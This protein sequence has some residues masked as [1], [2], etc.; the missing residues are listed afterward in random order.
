MAHIRFATESDIP[1]IYGFIL[2]MAR[3]EKLENEVDTTKGTANAIIFFHGNLLISGTVSIDSVS[4]NHT[5]VAPENGE[6]FFTGATIVIEGTGKMTVADADETFLDSANVLGAAY[7]TD[8]A[9]V[10]TSLN[11][12]IASTVSDNGRDVYVYGYVQTG[13]WT[14]TENPDGVTVWWEHP[15]VVSADIE[16]PANITLNIKGTLEIAE[17][18]VSRDCEPAHSVGALPPVR[19]GRWR[20]PRPRGFELRVGVDLAVDVITSIGK[21]ITSI[22]GG[23]AQHCIYVGCEPYRR[24]YY[25]VVVCHVTRILQLYFRTHP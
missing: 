23:E 8:D 9:Y 16:I 15:Y 5:T 1:L 14:D 11:D 10:L 18:V 20:S 25:A 21:V 4:G 19:G 7:V 17:G 24:T 22:L 3:Y 12:A 13:K 6:D 2:K